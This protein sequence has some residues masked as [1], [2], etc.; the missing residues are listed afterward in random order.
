MIYNL[1]DFRLLV[2]D[3][4]PTLGGDGVF[5]LWVLRACSYKPKGET[6][7]QGLS[8]ERHSI[9]RKQHLRYL[10]EAKLNQ[11]YSQDLLPVRA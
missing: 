10:R 9:R 6:A 2:S 3:A 8:I 11:D 1:L 4:N 5:P 7:H